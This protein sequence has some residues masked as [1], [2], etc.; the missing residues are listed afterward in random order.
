MALSR[1]QLHPYQV[2]AAQFIKENER[3]GLF[4]DMGL[5]KTTTALTA[6][7]DFLEDF[8]FLK[9]L[10]I[11]PLRVANTVWHAEASK[12]EHLKHLKINVCTGNAKQRTKQLEAPGDVYV[13]NRELVPWL[14]AQYAN[15][16]QW[17]MLIIDESSSFKSHASQRFKALKRVVDDFQSLV[18]LTGTPSP[19]GLM[20]LWSQLYLVDKGERLG[21]NITRYR[22]RFFTQSYDGYSWTATATAEEKVKELIKD[23]V[24]SL[25]AKDHLN[26]P[27]RI[28]LMESI[29][30]TPGDKAKYDEL[31]SEFM[32]FLHAGQIE[33]LNAAALG[34][35]LLQFCNGAIYDTDKN[36]HHIHDTK[37]KALREIVEDNPT[38][39]F[40]VA[41]NFKSDLARLVKAFP[42]A[43][44]LDKKGIELDRWNKGEIKMLLAHPASAGHG[45]NAQHGGSIIVWFGL[46][47][48]LELY[49]QFNARLHRQGQENVVRVFHLV[50]AGCI[51]EK[52]LEALAS[53]AE[54]QEQLLQYLRKHL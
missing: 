35:K 27:S 28:D 42:E 46:N 38:E 22:A 36:V 34:Q 17:D 33:A 39:N 4:L 9:V 51:D 50:T 26:L 18:L 48:S 52:V 47:W 21:P 5:G 25:R 37:I 41:Y 1:E 29:E 2:A 3:C 12:W 32:L 54:S 6:A 16:W 44:V 53:K 20:D 31:E 10:I 40:L 49:Q 19:N 43:V 11:A 14:V 8:R 15:K 13:I 45:L 7:A 23:K 30:L 24:I